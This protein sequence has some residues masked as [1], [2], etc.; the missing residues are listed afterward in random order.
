LDNGAYSPGYGG[1]LYFGQDANT[2]ELFLQPMQNSAI[3]SG[4]NATPDYNTCAT[5][6]TPASKIVLN[7]PPDGT[8][9]CVLTNEERVAAVRINGITNGPS[10]A[11]L[12]ITYTTWERL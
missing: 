8:V 10:G 1:D 4:G 3:A 5:A 9:I 6:R 7:Q 11:D 2:L 12:H